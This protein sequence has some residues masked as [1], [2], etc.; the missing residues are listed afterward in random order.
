[1]NLLKPEVTYPLD[2]AQLERTLTTANAE[3]TKIE[4][5]LATALT[6]GRLSENRD[7]LF[8]NMENIIRGLLVFQQQPT[9][10]AFALR[11]A[12]A[13]QQYSIH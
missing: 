13:R 2:D 7:G 10:Y 4:E 8:S 6:N 1:M 5:K 9:A 12:A 11:Y 3:F